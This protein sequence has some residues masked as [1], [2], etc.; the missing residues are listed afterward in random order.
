MSYQQA[1]RSYVEERSIPV[2]EA[3]CWLWLLSLGSHG[4]GQACWPGTRRVDVAHRL[5]FVAF[6]GDIPSG[7]LVQHS[8]D[9]RWCVAPHHLSLGT[10]ATNAIDKQRKGRAAKRLSP[11][12]IETIRILLQEKKP[13]RAIARDF[14]VSQRLI[15]WIEQGRV[16][17]HI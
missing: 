16:W 14:G 13:K 6:V 10:D 11:S 3:G 8:C 1:L 9:A 2:P 12:D 7:M 5:S 4:Y 17:S 15:H